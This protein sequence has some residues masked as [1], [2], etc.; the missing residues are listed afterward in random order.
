[1]KKILVP[2]D[3]S[4]Q[5]KYALKLAAEIAKKTDAELTLLHVVEIP[6]QTSFNTMGEATNVDGMEGVFVMKMIEQ[7]KK[8][9]KELRNDE[10]LEDVNLKTE[11][12]A[13]NTYYNI[14]SII[15]EYEPELV[16]M[17]T[18]GSSG[19]DEILIGSN[20]EK[21]VRN[22][23]CP[24]LTLKE[25]IS[26]ANIDNVVFATSLKSD[27]KELAAKMKEIAHLSYAKIHLLK[28][29]TPNNFE[30]STTTYKRMD[31]YMKNNG[32]EAEKHIHN[33]INEE[34]GILEFAKDN[35]I[36]LIAMGT[37]GRKGLMHLLSGS[38]AEDVVN[39]SKRPVLTLKIAD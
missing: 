2:T 5:A 38:I 32:L 8:K 15:N 39:H 9:L 24:V 37:H 1:M 21:V 31:E 36:D 13:G 26:L 6:G 33:G 4:D 10:L 17:G 27:D 25:E 22:A 7:G 18:S 16:V 19:V 20:A 12:K 3:F 35:N 30:S 29:N 14:S 23:K 11:L 28:I 34:E